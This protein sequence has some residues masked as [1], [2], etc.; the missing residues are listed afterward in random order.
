MKQAMKLK[1]ARRD[2]DV[3]YA[4]DDLSWWFVTMELQCPEQLK[5]YLDVEQDSLLL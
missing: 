4:A 2:E 3:T 1:P 5:G